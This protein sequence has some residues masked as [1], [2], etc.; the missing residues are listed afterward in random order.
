MQFENDKTISSKKSLLREYKTKKRK[1]VN[2][3]IMP[4]SNNTKYSNLIKNKNNYILSE[5][6]N[7]STL[8]SEYKNSKNSKYERKFRRRENDYN[9]ISEVKK[10][11]LIPSDSRKTKSL[12]QYFSQKKICQT[13]QPFKDY[14]AIIIS[15]SNQSSSKNLNSIYN[16]SY[17][18]INNKLYINTKISMNEPSDID[19][20]NKYTLNIININ[21]VN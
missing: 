7:K 16:N 19:K 4:V 18:N 2:I 13:E 15:E 17:K 3:P 10:F 6:T 21:T 5:K 9:T 14:K 8:T 1:S 12:S 11:T 20:K